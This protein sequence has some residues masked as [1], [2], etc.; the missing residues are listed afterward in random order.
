MMWNTNNSFSF[1]TILNPSWGVHLESGLFIWF[2][3]NEI[4]EEFVLS[5]K[6]IHNLTGPT[7][8]RG[9]NNGQLLGGREN[10]SGE[11]SPVA[12]SNHKLFSQAPLRQLGKLRASV[13]L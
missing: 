3:R 4:L 10:Q 1:E 7:A 6:L 13:Q 9:I 5:Q 12:G 11:S 2:C 8:L